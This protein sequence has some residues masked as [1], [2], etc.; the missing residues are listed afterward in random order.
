[1]PNEPTSTERIFISSSEE[2]CGIMNVPI[3]LRMRN[4]TNITSQKQLRTAGQ[5]DHRTC[6]T[7]KGDR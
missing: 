3:V 4:Y 1:M 7:I 6:C 2:Q 5:Y